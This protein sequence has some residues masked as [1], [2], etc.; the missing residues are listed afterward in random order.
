MFEGGVS[1]KENIV[2]VRIQQLL[3][4][5]HA[6]SSAHRG[7]LSFAPTVNYIKSR[8]QAQDSPSRVVPIASLSPSS[9]NNLY[10]HSPLAKR[11]TIGPE[12][13]PIDPNRRSASVRASFGGR[14]SNA[15][16]AKTPSSRALQKTSSGDDPLTRSLL[17]GG[18]AQVA[19]SFRARPSKG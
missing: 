9:S 12:W 13:R 2:S 14:I 3:S 1:V 7:R 8:Q 6:Y 10:T 19:R 4:N 18:A 11:A 16:T 5:I 17:G 15:D